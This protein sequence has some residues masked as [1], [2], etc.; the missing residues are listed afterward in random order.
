MTSLKAIPLPALKRLPLYYD[1]LKMHHEELGENVSTGTIAQALNLNPIQVRKDLELTGLAGRPKLGFNATELL[2]A[3]ETCLGWDNLQVAFLAGVGNLGRALLSYPGFGKY[4]L[5]ILAGFDINESIIGTEVGGKPVF[6]M[7]KLANLVKRMKV[8]IGILTVP[9]DQ[10]QETAN[11]FVEAGI[12]AIWNF[13]P[14]KL[15]LLPRVIV[16][17]EN[18]ATSLA[19]LSKKLQLGRHQDLD[20]D[21]SE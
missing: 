6:P 1:Y 14:R 17:N 15:E 3:L 10:A 21:I 7:K 13:T 5:E 11:K 12:E 8:K 16:Q 18:F 19:I 20:E 2:A 9:A 4:G